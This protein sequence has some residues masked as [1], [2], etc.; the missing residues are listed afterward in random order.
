MSVSPSRD[1]RLVGERQLPG[2]R[3]S[4]SARYPRSRPTKPATNASAGRE[5][6]SAGVANWASLPPTRSTATWSPSLIA[7]SMSWV[8]NTI[9][10]PRSACSRRNSS[11]SCCAHHRVDR[12]ERFV[13]QHHR[14]VG[15]QRSGDA[16]RAAAGRRTAAPGS[17][18]PVRGPV[19]TRSSSSRACGA[20][21][22]LVLA[23]Q[24]RHGRDVV[25]DG[26]V[27]EQPGVLDDVADAAAQSRRLDL[28]GVARRRA[29]CA[30]T[31]ARSSG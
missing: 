31:S 26:A 7:S 8:T 19:P 12:P 24:E 21:R 25:D 6:S 3:R 27:R 2:L 30:R 10:L 13:H 22:A 5:S 23:E 28:G 9:V 20:G 18:R 15:G 4:P 1:D 14:R 29:R 11:C 16:R 17:G